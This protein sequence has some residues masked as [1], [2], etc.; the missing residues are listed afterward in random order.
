[1]RSCRSQVQFLPGTHLIFLMAALSDKIGE[2]DPIAKKLSK[3][4][5]HLGIETVEDLIFYY[6]HRYE[7]FS[8]LSEISKLTAGQ[9]AVVLGRLELIASRRSSRQRKYLTEAVISDDSGSTKIVWFNQPWMTKTLKPGDRLLVYG[10][11][12]G[13]AFNVYFNSPNWQK[14]GS[15]AP[16]ILPVYSLTAGVTSKQI[17]SLVGLALS[18]YGQYL[19]EF[20]PNQVIE[21][22]KLKELFW[23]I[24]QIHKPVSL[25]NLSL[26]RRRLSFDELLLLQLKSQL[27]RRKLKEVK[28]PQINFNE[29]KTKELVN[30][31][32][33]DL[34]IDQ[35]RSAWEIIKDLGRPEPM[36][37]LLEGDVGS[38][39]T[40]V[41]IMAM[42]AT[43]VDGWQSALMAPTEIL[44]TQH[45]RTIRKALESSGARVG[46]LTSGQKIINDIDVGKKDFLKACSSGEIDIIV[47][48]HSLIQ[49]GIDFKK[50]ALV[51]VD[52]QHRFG[53]RQRQELKN[54]GGLTPHF[55]S[56]TATPIPRTM[57]LLAY[58]DLDISLIKQLPKGRL[59][60]ITKVVAP[61]HR[62]AAYDF[63]NKQVSGGRQVFVI[64]PL[65]DPSDKLG[66]KSVSEEHE[67]LDEEVFPHLSVGLLHGRL[68][69]AEKEEI[70]NNFVSG[71]IK[72]LVA[73]SVIEVGV[74]VP[75]ATIMMI[76]GAERFG[77]AQ[78]HQFRGRVGRGEFQ[79]YCF[80]FSDSSD[81]KTAKRLDFISRNNDGFSLSEYDLQSR[82][83]GNLYGVEQSGFASGLKLADINNVELIRQTS[84]VAK[85]LAGSVDDFPE[86]LERVEKL[87]LVDH[88]E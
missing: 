27:S 85:E 13:D 39:K 6:P 68:K 17:S 52:E 37:R 86:L 1:M 23:S 33:F 63:I 3:K 72:I 38:G 8:V 15:V 35:K 78:L 87:G 79:S 25:N 19:K 56:L 9:E 61:Q 71:K 84:V 42:H 60:I 41:A 64:C 28:A 58:G 53:V 18:K 7:D 21:D 16:G 67:K 44:A 2:L 49:S 47:G 77:L 40:L 59:P 62:V 55:L 73:T 48:T 20:L 81:E 24:E 82:G 22:N 46:L 14:T 45:Y 11:V 57:A 30:S 83:S 34:T 5:Q 88:W 66:V 29:I 69:P 32:S 50:L 75:N 54:K 10:K 26:A 4:L 76:E 70:M 36:N 31:L 12:A 74:D 65:I 80:L 51:I 43:F